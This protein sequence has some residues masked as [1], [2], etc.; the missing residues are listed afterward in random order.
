MN[1]LIFLIE[2]SLEKSNTTIDQIKY[3][4]TKDD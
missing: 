4:Q 2:F 1:L 3:F